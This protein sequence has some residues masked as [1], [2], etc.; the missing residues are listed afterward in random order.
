[1]VEVLTAT[2][3]R[4]EE[5]NRPRVIALTGGMAE[6][7]QGGSDMTK[8][9]C[10]IDG[11]GKPH[12]AKGYCTTHYTQGDCGVDG[13]GKP[14]RIRGWCP[15]HYKRFRLY[16]SP[17]GKAQR[18]TPEQRFLAKVNKDAPNGCWEWTAHLDKAGY[19]R[20]NPNRKPV[21]AHRWA[22]ERWTGPI[23]RGKAI[24]HRCD[25]PRCVNPEHL[26]AA[27]QT[28]NL[29]DM[30]SKGRGVWGERHPVTKLTEEDVLE[31]RRRFARGERPRSIA[32]DFDVGEAGVEQIGMG[33][34]WVRL[35][36]S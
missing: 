31:I 9:T 18:A 25:N 22:Y 34:T 24:C 19:G 6:T 27:T 36:P 29:A 8:R 14:A 16:G 2:V 15:A 30:W 32:R 1:M 28:E 21:F 5:T 33:K 17:T 3:A 26:F 10:S 13:C 20:F 11:C 35:L 23:P 7:T 4:F 12:H